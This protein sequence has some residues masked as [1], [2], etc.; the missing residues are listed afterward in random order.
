MK[1][2]HILIGIVFVITIS[3]L[4]SDSGKTEFGK[5]TLPLGRVSV[6][7]QG[8]DGWKRAM[9]KKT[10]YVGD[11]IRTLAK[12]RCEISLRGGG[13]LR[14]G[15]NSEL[16]L[17]SADVKPMKKEFN[18]NLTKGNIWVSAK[19]AFGEK[20][21]VSVRTPT[22]VAA[23][24]GTTYRATADSS[25]SS[26]LVYSGAVDVNSAKKIIEERKEKRKSL[27]DTG[28][29]FKLGPV[30]K[31]E[32]PT[33]VAGP[34]EVSLEDWIKLA[35]GWCITVRSDGKYHLYEFDKD[36]DAKDAFVRWNT[37]L[38]LE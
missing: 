11:K 21:N 20:K 26:V 4:M 35:K 9:P 29:P 33:E 15:E 38:D 10:V 37:K 25:E 6:Q 17:T 23:I 22:A 2:I 32:A 1:R 30:E 36:E 19:A 24:R 14:I 34:F 27:F 31:I 18:A 28:T 13:K 12:S 3:I 16:E 8:D 5:I 7:S